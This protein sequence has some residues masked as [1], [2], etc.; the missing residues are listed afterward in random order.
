[1][2]LVHP[3]IPVAFRGLNTGRSKSLGHIAWSV[4]RR[5]T[6]PIGSATLTLTG[7]QPGSDIVIL[8]AGTEDE[9]INVDAHPGT[10]YPFTFDLF[11]TPTVVDLAIY[12]AG[13]VP[14]TAVRNFELPISNAVLPV[15]QQLDRNYSNP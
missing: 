3:S 12:K 1:M 7:L 4:I 9:L 8:R 14:Y 5:P 13:C 15:S 6:D 11:V 2:S 10:S